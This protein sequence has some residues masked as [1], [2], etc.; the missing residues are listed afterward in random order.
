M[1]F[2]EYVVFR[3]FRRNLYIILAKYLQQ[4]GITY[5]LFFKFLCT[6]LKQ[7]EAQSGRAALE[8]RH[9]K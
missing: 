3:E 5:L 4:E 9:G 8:R 2:C 1:T 6:N 7:N